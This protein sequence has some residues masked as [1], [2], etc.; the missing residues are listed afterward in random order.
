M[1]VV[2][3]FFVGSSN[4]IKAKHPQYTIRHNKATLLTEVIVLVTKVQ[5]GCIE[6]LRMK[7]NSGIQSDRTDEGWLKEDLEESLLAFSPVLK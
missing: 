6:V 7:I 4:R 5:I 2:A 1:G 3:N